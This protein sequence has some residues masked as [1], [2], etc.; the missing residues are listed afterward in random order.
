AVV[1]EAA[2]PR[3]DAVRAAVERRR[4]HRERLGE[5]PR[6]ALR[7]PSEETRDVGRGH[8]AERARERDHLADVV[9]KASREL[10]REDA[11]EAPAEERQLARVAVAQLEEAPSEALADGGRRADVPA[12][13]PAV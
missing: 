12:E 13:T 5:P 2:L 1:G 3:D 11:A 4:R 8:V 10:A 7:S 9:G 6:P